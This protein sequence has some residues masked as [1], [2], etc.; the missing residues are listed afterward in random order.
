[1]CFNMHVLFVK[2]ELISSYGYDVFSYNV[3][4]D[5]GYILTVFRITGGR[6]SPSVVRG[7]KPVVMLHHGLLTSGESWTLQH[8]DKN[9]GE[10]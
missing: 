9:L 4:T 3:T 10:K 6:K 2:N 7:G 5:D 8:G 1:M